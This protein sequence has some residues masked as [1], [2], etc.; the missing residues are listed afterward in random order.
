MLYLKFSIYL[1]GSTSSL[2][3]GSNLLYLLYL[4]IKYKIRT[5]KNT[6]AVMQPIVLP[7]IIFILVLSSI[8]VLVGIESKLNRFI[9]YFQEKK[10]K[11]HEFKSGF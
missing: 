8:S 6:N 3:S 5:I 2:T 4:L 7:T 9:I 10:N 1:S 11:F